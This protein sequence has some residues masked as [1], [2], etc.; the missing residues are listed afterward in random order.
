MSVP[1]LYVR[2]SS[3]DARA[4][5]CRRAARAT[6]LA[7]PVLVELVA[8]PDAV[9]QRRWRRPARREVD[10]EARRRGRACRRRTA[11]PAESRPWADPRLALQAALDFLGV[12]A[13]RFA[14]PRQLVDERHRRRRNAFSAC[15]VISAD[16]SDIHS[17]VRRANGAK[18]RWRA[19]SRSARRR[20][21]DDDALRLAE[22]VER[23][24]QPQVL[25]RAGEAAA[26][27]SAP[28]PL[29][30]AREADRHLRRDQ[31][32]RAG[33]DVRPRS[34]SSCSRTQGDVG[35]SSS[36]TGV[37]NVTQ[38][39]PRRASASAGSVVNESRPLSSPPCDQLGQ[40]RLV[41]G[42]RPA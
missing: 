10:E 11:A 32:E 5:R 24:A 28:V 13:D 34:R 19:R 16:S 17:I 41:D 9:E 25:R 39:T 23:L 22:A 31:H 36:S 33:P 42:G 18:Q 4:R 26:G 20:A 37:S 1:G 27:S 40:A 8:R 12:R 14:E 15:L 2:P 21:A 7:R 3:A 35:P 30:R 6:L 29:Q 38:R